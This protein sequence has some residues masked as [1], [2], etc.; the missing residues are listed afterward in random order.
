MGVTD[1][2]LAQYGYL[3]V[4]VG[5]GAES[6][7][8]PLPGETILVAAGAYAGATHH[9]SASVVVMV[10]AAA[11]IGGDNVGYWLG[12]RYGPRVLAGAGRRLGRWSRHLPIIQRMFDRYG[13]LV[14]VGGRFI[15]V[16]RTYAAFGAGA[17]KMRWRKFLVLNTVGGLGW[18]ALVGFGSA[19]LG[20]QA[21]TT[22]TYALV[23]LVAVGAAGAGLVVRAGRKH[24][25]AGQRYE[26]PPRPQ[27]KAWAAANNP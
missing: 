12:R 4:A 27:G 6:M 22:V 17:T 23:A 15:S 8:A 11:A 14:V 5:I 1:Q 24:N 21:G 10:A 9:L 25:A 7:G 2:L 26:R 20:A 3:T 18:A 16:V 13:S 19:A